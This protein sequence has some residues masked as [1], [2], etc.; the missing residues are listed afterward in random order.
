MPPPCFLELELLH[1]STGQFLVAFDIVLLQAV[2][3]ACD[4][5]VCGGRDKPH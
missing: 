3:Q 2:G 5:G 1:H 4:S